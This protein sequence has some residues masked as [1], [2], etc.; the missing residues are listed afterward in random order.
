MTRLKE[1]TIVFKI[2]CQAHTPYIIKI[3]TYCLACRKHTNNVGS[4]NT[5]MTNKVIRN[6]SKCGVRLSDK[7]RFMKQEPDKKSGHNKKSGQ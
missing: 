4:W 6:K 5:T 1:T 3:K 7:S 2:Y